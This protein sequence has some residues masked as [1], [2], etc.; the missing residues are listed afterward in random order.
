MRLAVILLASTG[1]AGGMA[2]AGEPLPRVEVISKAPAFGGQ[3]FGGA[4]AYE[5]IVAVAHMEADP[6]AQDNAGIVDLDK[7][8]RDEQGMVAYDVDVVI[9][10][11]VDAAKARQVMIYDVA[12]RGMKPLMTFNDAPFM[13][14]DNPGNGFLMQQGFTLVWSGW[15]GDIA[16]KGLIGARL[17]IATGE[18][19][20]ITGRI[21]AETIFDNP[22][23]DLITLP[24]PAF[25]MGQDESGLGEAG[26]GNAILTV[27][28]RAG[29]P[30][31]VVD[32]A[33]WRFEDERHVRLINKP[34]NDAGA[35]YRMSYV[36]RDPSV[37]G[38]GFA[39]VRD[40]V[41][42]LRSGSA[43]Q[44]NPLADIVA[45]ACKD[46]GSD[47]CAASSYDTVVAHGASQSGRFLRDFV[48][49]GF[50]RDTLGKRVFDGMLVVIAGGRRT[51]TNM[52][53]AQPGEFSRQHEGHET[54]GFDFPFAYGL[55]RDPI[56]QR[57]DGIL[58]RCS[59]D[60]T[61]PNI[62][63]IDT[64]GEFWQ[65]GSSLVG[66][67]GDGMDVA[68]PPSVR[69]FMIAGGSH[70]PGFVMPFCK[71]PANSLNYTAVERALLLA[72]VDWTTTG[73]EPPASRW[74]QVA[75]GELLSPGTLASPDLS[76][77][78]V[79]WPDVVNEP[80]AS[81]GAQEWPVLVPQVDADGNDLPGIRLPS[82]DVPVATYLGWNL[83]KAGFAEDELCNIFGSEIPFAK[84]R[85]EQPDDP[86][87]ALAERYPGTER[88]D[89]VHASIEKLEQEG[90]LLPED[91][92]RMEEAI[93]R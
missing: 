53:F 65:A 84:T 88:Q 45:N 16:G 56:T 12:N 60:G 29:D 58:A 36:A 64:S 79:H 21:T 10:R 40:L 1:I 54:P 77:M 51:F 3:S 80:I 44:D 15:Q 24:Y 59:E 68:F 48:W 52:R 76:A 14:D 47:T 85:E 42:F 69:A 38:L 13:A 28:E 87:Q 49:Q 4:G 93:A 41:S 25:G 90:L 61:C 7:A 72:M 50:N 19:G 55:Q 63:H 62:F 83:R 33:D 92:R 86:R 91:A 46:E 66:T 67:D 70:A 18:S 9:L 6:S 32:P 5:R 73:S 39:A 30:A 74:P 89:R 34:T 43:E 27:R 2:H 75:D 20:P 37:A 8:P 71:Y 26:Q 31:T 22:A 35:I 57:E 81:L 17:P 82:V 23:S 78:D 11:P